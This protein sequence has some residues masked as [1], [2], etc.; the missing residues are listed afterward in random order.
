MIKLRVE[1]T[2]NSKD[3]VYAVAP[4]GALACQAVDKH[5][6]YEIQSER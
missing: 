3:I 2:A 4:I 6:R 5:F 1:A